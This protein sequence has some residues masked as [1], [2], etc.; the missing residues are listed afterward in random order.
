MHFRFY[1]KFILTLLVSILII[2]C[3]SE[4]TEQKTLAVQKLQSQVDSSAQ[5]SMQLNIEKIKEY[6][7]NAKSQLDYLETNFHDTNFQSAKYI[8]VYY[9]NYKLM[10]KILKGHDRLQSEITYSKNQLK[11]LHN[12]IENGFLTDSLYQ[13]YFDGETKAV[14]QIITTTKTLLEWETKSI[15]RYDGMKISID[16]VIT[17]LQNQGYR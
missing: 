16:S 3:V 4:K 2:S 1:S 8:D 5:E 14:S 7:T 13:E 12:D 9:R 15:H 6:K 10:T 17:E 11:T